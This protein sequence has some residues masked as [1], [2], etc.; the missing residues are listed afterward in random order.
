MFPIFPCRRLSRG[1]LPLSS[2]LFSTQNVYACNVE[3]GSL[4]RAG[5]MEAARQLFDNM[6]ERDVVSWNAIITGYWQNGCIEE[7]KKLF[8]SMPERNVVSWNSMI[9]GCVENERIDEAREY[10]LMMPVR[11]TASWNA[12]ISGFVRCGWV[13]E[14]CRLFDEMPRRNVISYTAMVDGYVRKGEIVRARALFD[15]MPRKNA[16]S[17][18]V[19]ISGHVENGMFDEAKELF[20]QMPDNHV[21]AM[22][23]MITGY[24]KE[25][26]MEEARIL[27][28]EIQYR[29]R[30][31][32]NA[33]ITGYTNNGIGDEALKLQLQMLRIGM[34]P[35]H[36]TLVSVLTACS[37]LT[38]LKEG[39]QIHVLV[40][41]NGLE[42]VVSVCNA[43]ITMY[44]KCGGILDSELAFGQIESPD[45]V[46]WNTII[47]AFAQHGLYDKALSF[48]NQMG[49]G[50]FEPDGITFLSIL[51]VC[52][53]VGRVDESLKLFDSM[54][55]NYGIVPGSEHY[56]CIVD[57][58]SR[59]GKLEKAYKIIEEMPFEADS[60]VWG[61][62]LSASRAYQNVG[63]AEIAA[64]KIV[65][66]EP[67]SSGVYVILSNLY[68][69]AGMWKEVTRVRG[70]MKEQG[71]KKQP[72]YSWTEIENKV[73][74]FLGGD[75]SHPDIV[76][77]YLEL[78]WMN[79]QMK[80]INDIAK[81]VSAWSCYG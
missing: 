54:V 15:R 80:N 42:S 11:N 53:H 29:D 63:F 69:A 10:F 26:K 78:K 36:L 4:S 61:A 75:V 68:A 24:C 50:G 39:R 48:F 16:V 41:K 6:S 70:L 67:Q 38:S 59:A 56:A 35:D 77:I 47:A 34:Q 18:T 20:D 65:E 72:A 44:S 74:C 12:M 62:L 8:W 28:E 52:G 21:T 31:A 71:V 30:V 9:A 19:M 37:C 23:A 40:L 45:I 25:G 3:I 76:R 64:R 55:R 66:L 2:K 79:L 73:H 13:E 1:F 58:L 14:A 33:M 57:I 51:S 22:T 49:L 7:S 5:K 17:W 27:F 32:W 46:S 43:L 81:I 60:A